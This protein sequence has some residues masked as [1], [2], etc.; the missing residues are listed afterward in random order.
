MR[1]PF[2]AGLLAAVLLVGAGC[3]DT[4]EEATATLQHGAARS[5]S[6]TDHTGRQVNL[7]DF[8]GKTVVLEWTNPECPFVKRHY[9]EGTMKSLAEKWSPKGVAWLAVNSTHHFTVDKNKQFADTYSLP[10]PVLDDHTGEVGRAYGA[11]TT[12]HVIVLHRG[13]IVYDG[14]IDDDLSG[15]KA[16]EL[17]INYVDL[18]LAA[19]TQGRRPATPRTT[20]YGCSVK[21]A[22][23]AK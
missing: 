19:A 11:K 6:L 1:I 21:Y 2:I 16:P 18:A 10:Y 7:D 22:D 20:P 8:R 3:E 15:E 13:R 14:A 5:F 23:K 17:R 4:P 12:P 9:K